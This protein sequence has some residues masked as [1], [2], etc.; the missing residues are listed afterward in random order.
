MF[1]N[2]RWVDVAL[3]RFIQADSIIPN[4]GW[5]LS[6]DRYAYVLGNPVNLVDPSGNFCTKVGGRSICTADDDSNGWWVPQPSKSREYPKPSG[7]IICDDNGFCFDHGR[8]VKGTPEDYFLYFL[9][10]SPVHDKKQNTPKYWLHDRGLYCPSPTFC[11]MVRIYHPGLDI[12][13]AAGTVIYAAAS[14]VVVFADWTKAYGWT[15]IIEHNVFGENFYTLYAHLGRIPDDKDPSTGIF[16]K[17]GDTVTYNTE[18][19][20]MGATKGDETT[21]PH[22]HFEARTSM[23]LNVDYSPKGQYWIFDAGLKAY[24][25][26]CSPWQNCWL[27]LGKWLSK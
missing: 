18:I 2:A 6:F 5:P 8:L 25:V 16:V 27:D 10:G 3:G 1:Y 11:P 4:G 20:L 17:K 24:Y 26:L 15:V 7:G 13:N 12:G 14:G 21:T 23:G 19:A 22:L 9:L